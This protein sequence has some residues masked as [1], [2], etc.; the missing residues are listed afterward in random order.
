MRKRILIVDN[1]P[2]FVVPL[3]SFLQRHGYEVVTATNS[4][5]AQRVARE[6][7]LHAAILDLRLEHETKEQDF[8]GLTLARRLDPAL[9]KI[10]L[11]AHPTVKAVREAL[12]RN[13]EGIP[14]AVAFL[15]KREPMDTLLRTVE[16]ALSPADPALLHCFN[17]TAMHA[18]PE[19]FQGL[20]PEGTAARL[21]EF[22]SLQKAEFTRQAESQMRQAEQHHRLSIAASILALVFMLGT[23]ALILW[24]KISSSVAAAMSG[25]L[26]HFVGV[27]FNQRADKAHQRV[28]VLLRESRELVYFGTLLA[29]ADCFGDVD[30]RDHYREMV[31]GAFLHRL[32][33]WKTKTQSA[34]GNL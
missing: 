3:A 27:L 34:G 13:H 9:P 20:G 7:P 15:G 18:L 6:G 21:G 4:E 19:T 1:M 8:S 26:I 33:G 12:S 28:E 23:C 31:F 32:D 11:T 25:I 10:I 5:E 24:Q 2:E 30:K 22:L 14:V 29:Y 17:A 16:L